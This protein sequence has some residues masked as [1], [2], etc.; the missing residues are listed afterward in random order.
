MT[1]RQYDFIQGIVNDYE[2]VLEIGASTGFNLNTFKKKGKKVFGVEPSFR[3]KE[4][5]KKLYNIDL[6]TGMYEDFFIENNEEVF[7]LIILSHVLEHIINPK[8]FIS[9]IKKQNNKYLYI[10]VPSFEIQLKSEPFGCFFYEHVNHFT[11][12]SL[13]NLMKKNGYSPL[14]LNINYNVNGE[15]P[16]Y[17][18]ICSLWKN[19]NAFYNI[20]SNIS[21]DLLMKNYLEISEKNFQSIKEKIDN[22][23]SD[24]KLAIWGTGSHTSR[25]LGMTNLVSKNIVKFYDSDLKKHKYKIMGKEISSF[26][27]QDL[28]SGY[29]DTILLSTFSAEKSILN[30]LQN[31]KVLDDS[32]VNIISLYNN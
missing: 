29:I 11:I 18:V 16:N 9:K 1:K 22:I 3:N 28:L 26:N 14:N 27:E 5:A 7:D 12:N 21:S 23:P 24:A 6:Y 19:T 15:S 25:L 20:E 4:T 30:Y 8:Q 17:P 32:I 31:K 2:S 10:E 13:N